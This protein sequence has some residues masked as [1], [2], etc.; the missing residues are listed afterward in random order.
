M[1]QAIKVNGERVQINPIALAA[2]FIGL[3]IKYVT[4]AFLQDNTEIYKHVE[5]IWQLNVG[6]PAR[7]YDCVE[8]RDKFL[9][10]AKLGWWISR[11]PQVAD[12]ST[13]PELERNLS[14][15]RFDCGIHRDHVNV[16]PEIAAQVAGYAKSRLREEGLHVLV[17]IGATT[18]DVASFVLSAKEG[19]DRYAFMDASVSRFGCNELHKWR[20]A[21]INEHIPRWLSQMGCS[22]D[23]IEEVPDKIDHYCPKPTDLPDVDRE[24][25]DNATMYLSGVIKR[26]KEDKFPLSDAW[27]NGL[28]LFLCGGGS[29]MRLYKESLISNAKSRMRG[30]VWQGF[31]RVNLPTPDG[32]FA[33]SLRE[34]EYHRLSVAYG[35]SYPIDDIGKI[36]PPSHVSDAKL[37]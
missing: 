16:V 19:E 11:Q 17:D 34:S 32:L 6:I 10:A 15:A 24:F 5:P 27:K 37:E 25:I 18:L 29:G 7:N 2:I 33:R 3:A 20:I 30:L 28:P 21:K 8:I 22:C 36:I 1:P 4:T 14:D 9:N 12:L 35:L 26:T 13:L 31:K 23:L